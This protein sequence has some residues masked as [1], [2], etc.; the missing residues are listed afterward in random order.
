MDESTNTE[1]RQIAHHVL[2]SQAKS[3]NNRHSIN[4]S[5]GGFPTLYLSVVSVDDCARSFPMIIEQNWFQYG[6]TIRP[7]VSWMVGHLVYQ[8]S[9]SIRGE[10]RKIFPRLWLH[11]YVF[12]ESEPALSNNFTACSGWGG[13]RKSNYFT[14]SP[15]HWLSPSPFLYTSEHPWEINLTVTFMFLCLPIFKMPFSS[16]LTEEAFWWL[17]WQTDCFPATVH[18]LAG[19]K[20]STEDVSSCDDSR[21]SRLPFAKTHKHTHMWQEIID[22]ADWDQMLVACAAMWVCVCCWGGSLMRLC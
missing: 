17:H 6:S 8:I 14:V 5:G 9:F 7:P 20:K 4:I 18:Y 13:K 2:R 1:L 12:S 21:K 22:F 19:E 3:A 15:Y 10:V 16:Q 11:F